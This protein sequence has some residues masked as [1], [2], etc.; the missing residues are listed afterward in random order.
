LP[1]SE[2]LSFQNLQLFVYWELLVAIGS[3]TDYWLGSFSLVYRHPC[4]HQ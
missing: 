2:L 3:I 4:F 1:T